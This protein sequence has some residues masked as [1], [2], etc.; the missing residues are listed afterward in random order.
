[1]V[2]FVSSIGSLS[3]K[4][5]KKANLGIRYHKNLLKEVRHLV[6]IS[7]S[8]LEKEHK[9]NHSEIKMGNTLEERDDC[10]KYFPYRASINSDSLVMHLSCLAD[11]LV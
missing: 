9:S 10:K 5:D 6:A 7:W 3:S 2:C 1:M 8:I 11:S 4:R